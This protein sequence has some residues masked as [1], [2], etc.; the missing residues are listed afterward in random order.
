MTFTDYVQTVTQD[1]IVPKIVDTILGGNVV[2]LRFLANGKPWSGETMKFPIKHVKNSTSQGAF[3]GFDTF[4]TTK[5]NTRTKLSFNPTGYYQSVVLSGME[6]DV[7]DTEAKVLDLVKT[8]MESGMQDMLDSLGSAFYTAQ[9]GKNFIGLPDIVDDGTTVTSY[10]GLARATY[11]SVCGTKTAATAGKASL[12]YLANLYDSASVGAQ[13][14]TLG[15][16]TEAVWT[17]LESLF[18]PTISGN[19]KFDGYAQVTRNRVLPSRAGL[20]GEVGFDALF[21]RGTP[22]VRDEKCTSGYLYLLN[23]DT[24]NWY[25]LKSHKYAN[26]SLSSNNIEQGP[27]A[28]AD[29]PKSFGFCWTGLKDPVNQYAEIGQIILMGNLIGTNPRLNSMGTGITTV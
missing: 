2:S 29:V 22:I 5:V 27:Y 8:E 23:E 9:S 16:T 25:G 20:Q 26:I 28:G 1:K 19:V 10:G 11:T 17:L 12:S 7:N 24:I 18:Q 3:D 4:D 14:P 13:K 15:I 6:V 21:F